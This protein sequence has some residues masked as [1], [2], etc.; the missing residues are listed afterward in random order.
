KGQAVA[1]FILNQDATADAI[2]EAI[3]KLEARAMAFRKR[4]ETLRAYMAVAMRKTGILSIQADDGTFAA[5]LYI[6]RDK[7]VDVFQ[8]ELV[9]EEFMRTPE[10][11]PPPKAAPDK[12]KIKKALEAGTDVPGARIVKKDRLELK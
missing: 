7:S 8:P 1:A 2:D 11:P 9:P 6:D 4:A 10:P 12:T 5:K 3:K